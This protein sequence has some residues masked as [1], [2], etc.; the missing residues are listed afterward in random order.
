MDEIMCVKFEELSGSCLSLP[1]HVQ[2]GLPARLNTY[3]LAI[4][5]EM[6]SEYIAGL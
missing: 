2:H 3:A 6:H 1:I 4:V 5:I